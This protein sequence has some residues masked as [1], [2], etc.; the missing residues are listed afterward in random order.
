MYKI[1]LADLHEKILQSG[2][3]NSVELEAR[4]K[5]KINEL[6]GLISEE[7]A[8]HII[9]NELGI[10]LFPSGREQ[11]KVK[12][13]YAGM[14]GIS[15]AGK[16]VRRFEVREFAKQ[17]RAGKVCN[18]LLGDETGTVRA[19]FWNDQVDR[20]QGVKEED[21]L[22]LKDIFVKEN[23][24]NKE[25]HVG[26]KTEIVVNPSNLRVEAVRPSPDFTRRKIEELQQAQEG[27]ELLGTVVQVFDPR[28]F[29]VCSFCNK[30][31][32]DTEQGKQ[33]TE[34]GLVQPTT[35]YVLT[36]ILD[37]GTGTI[38]STFWKNQT[39]HLLQRDEQAMLSC[40]D[41]PAAF[42]EIKNELYGEQLKV[43]GRVKKN[44]LFDRLEFNV[45]LAEKA[46]PQEEIVRLESVN[47]SFS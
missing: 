1:P 47:T 18:L 24:G 31:V 35:S 27:V 33:C 16:V 32:Q 6:A 9:A 8:A 23:N 14:R 26:T 45:Q 17:D 22:L 3:I 30:R 40:K 2:K 15:T 46:S 41:N 36:L 34:H 10:S 5:A 13:L 37:D 29:E 19:V 21:V 28:F 25:I 43:M 7:G 38:R 20:L 4:M 44:E 39:S 12:E 42:E 11:L